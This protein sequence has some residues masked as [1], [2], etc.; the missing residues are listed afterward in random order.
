ML[1]GIVTAALVWLLLIPLP[2]DLAFG[3]A[4]GAGMVTAC[5]CVPQAKV[6]RK[7]FAHLRLSVQ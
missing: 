1:W 6:S 4:L 2:I 5:F 7:L 3:I